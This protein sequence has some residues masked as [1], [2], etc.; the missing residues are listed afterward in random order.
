MNI[1]IID[2]EK[3]IREILTDILTDEG[4]TVFDA[5]DGDIGIGI[6]Q[7]EKIDI[8]FLDVWMPK[9]G[10]I[11]VLKL[12][13]EDFKNVEVVMISGHAKI[14]QAV[15]ATK[16]GAYDFIEKPLTINKIIGTVKNIEKLKNS[17][18][19]SSPVGF[20]D[21]MIGRS[22]KMDKINE[23]IESAA[24]TNTRILIL[25]EN[26]TG[27]ELVARAIHY[28]SERKHFP[29]ISINCA[30]IPENL[31]EAELFGH[32]K[33]AFTGAHI[34]RKGKFELA[35]EGTLFLD[36]IGELPLNIQ[37]KL[38][39]VL[40]D[41]KI[42]AIGS[43]ET[44]SVD[45]RLI[46]ATNKDLKE[47]ISKGNFREDL[48]YRLNVIPISLPPLRERKEDIDLLIDHFLKYLPDINKCNSKIIEDGAR[49]ALREYNWPGN[50]RQL[51]NIIE[52]LLIMVDGDTI[53]K[54][55]VIEYLDSTVQEEASKYSSFQLKEAREHFERDFITRKL[56]EN[57]NNITQTAKALGMYPSNLHMKITKMKINL[58]DNKE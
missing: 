10:G 38:L 26:G 46:A 21:E 56:K 11:D 29:F 27:K 3:S 49:E 40:Q 17:D 57:N 1:L 52:R 16:L 18:S 28:R 7:K 55:D 6:L 30:A 41:M 39:R 14:D 23:L 5:E 44:K 2:D 9:T 34:E 48:Y 22:E 43:S 4:F 54:E 45:V 51:R 58:Y 20:E 15:K 33:G 37:P 32:Q 42:T 50:I 53:R 36:E 19:S 47:E 8:C 25:G 13:K 35:D 12:I 31:L 24:Q